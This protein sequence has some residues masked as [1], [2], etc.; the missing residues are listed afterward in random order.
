[1]S[2]VRDLI[3]G[4]LRLIGAVDADAPLT[5]NEASDGLSALNGLI[6]SLNTDGLLVYTVLEEEFTLT[7]GQGAY[8]MG[9]SGNFNTT[10]PVRID[11]AKYKVGDQEYPIHILNDQEWQQGIDLRT[12]GGIPEYLYN[13][14]AF[15][16]ATVNIW[17]VPSSAEKLVLWS[18][19]AIT[20]FTAVTDV[21][22]LP[23]GYERMLRYNLAI[24]LAPEFSRE[25]SGTVK[26]NAAES[27]A[28]IK[29]L[30]IQPIYLACDDALLVPSIYGS[31]SAFLGG[32]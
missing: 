9:P 27:L 11:D 15:P 2:T 12:L 6:G 8:T 1:M 32:K 14:N 28:D 20:A 7:G 10:R 24:E 5:A 31:M 21:L 25:P 30:N 18:W 23:P 16:L 26:K 19:K 13:D 22:S 29:R 4:A 17:P 3:A